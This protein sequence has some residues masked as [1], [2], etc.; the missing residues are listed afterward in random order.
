[1]KH[2]LTGLLIL[3]SFSSF[4]SNFE[5]KLRSTQEI[6]T[7]TYDNIKISGL[8]IMSSGLDNVGDV[9][10]RQLGHK[11]VMF[12]LTEPLESL[13]N[14]PVDSK[15][16]YEF[17]EIVT[18]REWTYAD[19]VNFSYQKRANIMAGGSHVFTELHCRG[20]K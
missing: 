5:K 9:L 15:G 4:A 6:T 19:E 10:C 17:F 2:L 16:N 11:S 20:N 14:A 3:T 13:K 8:P 1:M 7:Y 18:P 12:A